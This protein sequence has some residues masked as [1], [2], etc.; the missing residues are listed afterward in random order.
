M[1][2]ACTQ[3]DDEVSKASAH[4][5]SSGETTLAKCNCTLKSAQ[6]F[7]FSKSTPMSSMFYFLFFICMH[8]FKYMLSIAKK[9]LQWHKKLDLKVKLNTIPVYCFNMYFLLA[10]NSSDHVLEETLV[11]GL[12]ICAPKNPNQKKQKAQWHERVCHN[13][14]MSTVTWVARGYKKSSKADK[15]EAQHKEQEAEYCVHVCFHLHDWILKA[16][17]APSHPA[18]LY[19][20]TRPSL[21][22][23][24]E[25]SHTCDIH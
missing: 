22:I 12:M 11:V 1:F 9:N 14:F 20:T 24:I 15:T 6:I 7:T 23:M 4:L 16:S 18:V 8:Y 21:W 3:L 19:S 10:M 17:T 13:C 25:E 2:F 5:I